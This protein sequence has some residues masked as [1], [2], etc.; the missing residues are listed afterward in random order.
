LEPLSHLDIQLAFPGQSEDLLG[1]L[2]SSVGVVLT[3][4]FLLVVE[5]VVDLVVE[6]GPLFAGLN[7]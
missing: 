3:T 4:S 7:L 1:D 2:C 5:E 6:G